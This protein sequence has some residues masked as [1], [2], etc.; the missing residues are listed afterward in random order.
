M[1]GED[2]AV[3]AVGVVVVGDTDDELSLSAVDVY[4]ADAGAKG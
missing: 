4:G 1:E 3:G 2:E